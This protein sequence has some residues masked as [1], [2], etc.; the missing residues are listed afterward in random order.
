[1]KN[2]LPIIDKYYKKYKIKQNLKRNDHK[3][4]ICRNTF[5]Y[6]IPY[7]GGRMSASSF[8]RELKCIGSDVDNYLC[9]HCS[10]IDRERHLFMYFDKLNLWYN[11]KGKN[12]LHFAPE[13]HLKTRI[14]KLKPEKYIQAD[15]YPNSEEIRKVDITKIDY[16][17]NYFDFVICCHVLEHVCDDV[18]AIQEIYRV[19]KPNCLAILQT[20]YSSI[21]ARSFQDQNILTNQLRRIFYGQEDHVRIYGHDIFQRLEMAGFILKIKKHKDVLEEFNSKYWG[22]N[23]KE[24]LIMV[25]KPLLK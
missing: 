22:V 19:L 9:P 7:R 1:M 21:L 3:C 16:P 15:L 23:N 18:K 8:I 2:Y 10:S 13:K 14:I 4:Y 24:D 17:E 5:K 25:Y 12:V 20:P 11:I 6:F